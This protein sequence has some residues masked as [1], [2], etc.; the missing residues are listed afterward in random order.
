MPLNAIAVILVLGWEYIGLYCFVYFIG[1]DWAALKAQQA[2]WKLKAQWIY[3][4]FH[5]L[6]HIATVTGGFLYV[7]IKGLT[8]NV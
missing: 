3:G 4:A 5:A 6:L 2:H 7:F 8:A 1:N